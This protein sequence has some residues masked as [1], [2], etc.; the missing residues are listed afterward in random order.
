MSFP[1]IFVDVY[2]KRY[3]GAERLSAYFS[4]YYGK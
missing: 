4:Q 2:I 1:T 3:K